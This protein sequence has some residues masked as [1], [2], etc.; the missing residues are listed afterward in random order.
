MMYPSFFELC[1]WCGHTF[2]DVE[3][4]ECGLEYTE[5]TVC[6]YCTLKA[7]RKLPQSDSVT[8]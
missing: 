4:E 3:W 5:G 8:V 1:E 6:P 7:L 2:S